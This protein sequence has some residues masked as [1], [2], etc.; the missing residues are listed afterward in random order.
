MSFAARPMSAF[1][2]MD[3]EDRFGNASF[4]LPQLVGLTVGFV[5]C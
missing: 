5:D 3:K 4:D 2:Q 1:R